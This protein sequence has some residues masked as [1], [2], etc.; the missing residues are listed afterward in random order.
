MCSLGSFKNPKEHAPRGPLMLVMLAHLPRK[1]L[2][3]YIWTL[4]DDIYRG[5]W[6]SIT[7]ITGPLGACSFG[8]LKVCRLGSFKSSKEHAP[9][10]PLM[11]VMLAHL[12]RNNP[13]MA[14]GHS[15]TG[16]NIGPAIRKHASTLVQPFENRPQHWS[17]HSKTGL[18]IGPPFRK[19]A[20]TL[21]PPFEINL[22]I[23][24]AIRKQASTLVPPIRKPA[25]TLV[26]P[27]EN[28]P[29]HWSRH[30][31]NSLN[32]GPAIRKPA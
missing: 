15:K 12:P 5:R 20:S 14:T 23:G 24:P 3:S 25:S 1:Q 17:P 32:I 11:L 6:A 8:L 4:A 10:G 7:S 21:V 16:L 19:Q 9:R 31:K 30:S 28:R 26:P 29:Q 18:N 27:F 22:N 13:L 2:L